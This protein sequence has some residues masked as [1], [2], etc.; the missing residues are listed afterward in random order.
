M[1][2]PVSDQ[3]VTNLLRAVWADAAI[4]QFRAQTGSD[5]EDAL[6][7]LLCNLMHWADARAFDFEGALIRARDHYAIERVEDALKAHLLSWQLI[8]LCSLFVRVSWRGMTRRFPPP[9]TVRRI[10]G[11]Y[12]IDDAAGAQ[13]RGFMRLMVRVSL[14]CR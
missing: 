3:T 4:R 12:V 7:D 14:P 8:P 9:W 1:T 11:G 2:L 13:S 6:G 10:P 5:Y